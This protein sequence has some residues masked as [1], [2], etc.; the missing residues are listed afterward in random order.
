[1]AAREGLRGAC[2][3]GEMP[4]GRP[5]GAG[6][7]PRVHLAADAPWTRS[8][9]GVRRAAGGGRNRAAERREMEVRVYLR[10][11]K[12]QGPLGKIKNISFLEGSNETVLN[13]KLAQL[14]KIY[15]FCV[16]KIFI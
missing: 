9:G 13:T 12:V 8:T 4:R 2:P 14:F 10:F 16:M 6:G 3:L 5:G 1:M 15:N 7:L 11:L